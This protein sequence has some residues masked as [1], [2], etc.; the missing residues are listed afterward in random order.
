[1]V[2]YSGAWPL[3]LNTVAAVKQVDPLLIKCRRGLRGATPQQLFRK[4]MLPAALPT[5]FVGI[6]LAGASAMLVLVV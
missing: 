4:V 3:L 1:M 5:I 2:M 6:R